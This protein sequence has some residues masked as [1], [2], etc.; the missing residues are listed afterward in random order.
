MTRACFT[1][2]G[3]GRVGCLTRST[4]KERT[5]IKYM[6]VT[7]KELALTN[8]VS[9]PSPKKAVSMH[10]KPQNRMDV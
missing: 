9:A 10:T 7:P 5:T 6:M 8:Q 2:Y 1:A 4:M 3:L